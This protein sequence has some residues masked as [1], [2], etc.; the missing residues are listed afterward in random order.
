MWHYVDMEKPDTRQ[1]AS[2]EHRQNESNPRWSRLLPLA[3]AMLLMATGCTKNQHQTPDV[4][5]TVTK[6]ATPQSTERSTVTTATT[7]S[8]PQVVAKLFGMLDDD[9][10]TA[11]KRICSGGG[12]RLCFGPIRKTPHLTPNYHNPFDSFLNA[13]TFDK[14]A[15]YI[16]VSW[17]SKGSDDRPADA[18]TVVCRVIGDIVGRVEP[19]A[20]DDVWVAVQVP[21]EHSRTGKPEVGYAPEMGVVGEAHNA[22]IPHCDAAANP[23][24]APIAR[25]PTP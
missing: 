16:S 23:A 18:F 10:L 20:I 24:N 7:R 19:P 4:P 13:G 3:A 11:D 15:N 2:A 22:V 1:F 17:P 9:G 5:V 25:T 8:G 21:K 12:F 6:I 14:D